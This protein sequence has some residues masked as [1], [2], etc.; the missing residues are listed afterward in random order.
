MAQ[1]LLTKTGNRVIYRICSMTTETIRSTKYP[2]QAHLCSM[3]F[4]PDYHW[5]CDWT[6][7][8]RDCL[9]DQSQNICIRPQSNE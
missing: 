8:C 1:K 5:W 2:A 6:G 3:A 7:I 9:F 4:D